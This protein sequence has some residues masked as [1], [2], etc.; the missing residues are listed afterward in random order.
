MKK[1]ISHPIRCEACGRSETL[2]SPK[3][4]P[5]AAVLAISAAFAHPP[6]RAK[7]QSPQE[8]L[9][10]RPSHLPGHTMVKQLQ[11]PGVVYTALAFKILLRAQRAGA[12]SIQWEISINI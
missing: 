5:R 4:A 6:T 8:L 10:S 7:L 3:F 1:K 12:F 2:L 9:V 11:T